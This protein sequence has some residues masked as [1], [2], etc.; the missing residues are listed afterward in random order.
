MSESVRCSAGI[1]ALA[2]TETIFLARLVSVRSESGNEGPACR[3]LAS[4]LPDLGWERVEIDDA[5]SVVATRGSGEKELLLLGHID[6]VPGGPEVRLDG[7]IL[8]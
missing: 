6:T 1:K 4:M 8:W 2:D 7:D 3:L 5:G